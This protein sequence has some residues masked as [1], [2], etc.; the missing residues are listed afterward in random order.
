MPSILHRA[1]VLVLVISLAV[2]TS[3]YCLPWKTN[4]T[5]RQTELTHPLVNNWH[6]TCDQYSPVAFTVCWGNRLKG[7]GLSKERTDAGNLARLKKTGS[8]IIR[9]GNGQR[10]LPL[11][12]EVLATRVCTAET[13]S[14][15]LNQETIHLSLLL[16]CMLAYGYGVQTRSRYFLDCS[17]VVLAPVVGHCKVHCC[18]SRA[19]PAPLSTRNS[20]SGC[21]QSHR[22]V[23]CCLV[24]K[25]VAWNGYERCRGFLVKTFRLLTYN[26]T[27][28]YLS[29]CIY[30]YI[31]T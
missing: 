4:K 31:Y 14:T 30:V 12:S 22:R 8:G 23:C 15:G 5:T 27:H 17:S 9:G 10:E 16:V 21:F 18:G 1:R 25:L 24:W 20:A 11:C 26:H 28:L 2:G 3:P 19:F 13:G 7:S 6:P 29:M